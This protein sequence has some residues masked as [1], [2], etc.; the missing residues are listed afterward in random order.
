VPFSD[1]IEFGPT[2]RRAAPVSVR[3]HWD[4]EGAN[5][6]Q[7]TLLHQSSD[8][9][10]AT[11]LWDCAPERLKFACPREWTIYVARG[12]LVVE[13]ECGLHNHLAVGSSARF[14][15]GSGVAWFFDRRAQLVI[16]CRDPLPRIYRLHGWLN[17]LLA[18]L[19]GSK[20]SGFANL[21]PT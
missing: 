2:K 4:F 6:A 7:I 20:S 8:G 15:A 1:A 21:P 5:P 16:F 10:A 11:Y 18:K 9:V 12:A 19:T 17:R 14:P 3:P 13:D